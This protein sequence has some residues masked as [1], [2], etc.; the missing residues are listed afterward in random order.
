MKEEHG[1]DDD[2]DKR[3]NNGYFIYNN[4]MDL[5]NLIVHSKCASAMDFR[6]EECKQVF[7]HIRFQLKGKKR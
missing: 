4:G 7:A 5:R 3:K 2:D 6:S 1:K